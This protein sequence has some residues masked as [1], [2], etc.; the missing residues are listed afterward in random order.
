MNHERSLKIATFNIWHGLASRGVVRFREF[1]SAARREERFQATLRQ[2]FDLDPD[3]LLLQELNPVS[4]QGREFTRALGGSFQGRVDQ[5]GLKLFSRGWPLN[6]A[7]GLGIVVRGSVRP[8]HGDCATK[9]MPAFVRLS[10]SLGFSGEGASFHLDEQRYAQLRSVEHAGL[11]RLL[12]V[13]MHLHHGFE[14]FPELID[15]LEN[16]IKAG[17]ISRADFEALLVWLDRARARRLGEID[18]LLE[19]VHRFERE[20]DGVVLGGDLN[21]T[22]DGAAYRALIADG[23]EDLALSSVGLKS[24]ANGPTWDPLSNVE[25]HRIQQEQGFEFPLPTF[26]NPEFTSIYRAFDAK[27]RRIDFLFAKGSLSSGGAKMIRAESKSGAVA[28]PVRL[29]NVERFGF[30]RT[31]NGLAPSDHFGLI[32]RYGDSK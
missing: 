6:L 4:V 28:E 22:A 10:G 19:V 2:L 3:I 9:S 26:D 31:A 25:N 30:P 32:A 13:N 8:L 24:Q 27:P 17:R 16:G 14:A 5:S 21:S 29:S 20:H 1:E 11:G 7:T 12:I 18:R 15:L 23:Y